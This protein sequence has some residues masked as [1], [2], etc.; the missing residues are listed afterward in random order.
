[1]LSLSKNEKFTRVHK[2]IRQHNREIFAM[3]FQG[4]TS[5]VKFVLINSFERILRVGNIDREKLMNS[6]NDWNE[7]YG[8]VV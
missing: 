7:K 5:T 6:F 3:Y 4:N 2:R 1:M 8:I